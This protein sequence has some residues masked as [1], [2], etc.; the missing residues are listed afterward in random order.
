MRNVPDLVL[1][2]ELATAIN[3]VLSIGARS[4]AGFVE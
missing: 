3:G 4:E 1:S 2:E